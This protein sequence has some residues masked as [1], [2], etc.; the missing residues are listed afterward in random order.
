MA[1]TLPRTAL[2]VLDIQQGLNDPAYTGRSTPDFEANVVKMLGACRA[3]ENTHVIHVSH[4]SLSESDRLHPSRPGAQ[5]MEYAAP[6]PGEIVKSKNVNSAFIGTD[7]ESTIRSLG[8]QRLVVIGL[9]TGH[10][11]SATVRMAAN[12]RVVDHP[13]GG[14]IPGH[15]PTGQIIVVSDATAMFTLSYGGKS[16]DGETLHTTSLA[17]L[18]DVFCVVRNTEEVLQLLNDAT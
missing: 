4:H 6:Q 17:T 2:L 9:A 5:F 1:A 15:N 16:F 11:I 8:I 3:A 18:D 14:V 13:H 12:L 10:C 7:L